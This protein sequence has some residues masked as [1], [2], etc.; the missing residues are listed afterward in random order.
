MPDIVQL[1]LC[2]KKT[3]VYDEGVAIDCDSHLDSEAYSVLGMHLC[4]QK[5]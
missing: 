3:A 2:G 1:L 4:G 5:Y